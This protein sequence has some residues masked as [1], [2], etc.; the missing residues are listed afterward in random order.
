M[1]KSHVGMTQCFLCGEPKEILIDRHLQNTLPRMA[2][3]DHKP[4]NK[5]KELMKQ[6]VILIEVRDTKPPEN[7]YRTGHL[8]V[9]KDEAIERIIENEE[10]KA[11]VLKN[12][13]A[14][15]PKVIAETIGLHA[16]ENQPVEQGSA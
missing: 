11:K 10:E 2:C 6:G 9:V 1:E 13:M 3:Y 8:W 15:I 7:Q 5:C 12:R 14:F 16:P 4:C